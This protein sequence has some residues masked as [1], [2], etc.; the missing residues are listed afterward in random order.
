M[1][2]FIHKYWSKATFILLL[3]GVLLQACENDPQKV[4]DLFRKQVAVE[5]AFNV[6]SFMSQDGKVKAKLTA[7][8]MVRS[9]ADSPYLEF[10]KTVHVDFY[11]DSATIETILDARYAK[12]M[13]YMR[14]VLLKDSVVVINR[15][16]GD[17]LRTQELWWDQN[18]EEFYTDKPCHINQR[19]GK[20]FAENGLRA[21]QNLNWYEFHKSS[22]TRLVPESGV[23][24]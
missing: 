2:S 12:Y 10:P 8:Y 23:P 1:Y 6:E 17:T 16:S 15:L 3:G 19:L 22:G 7:P 21:A 20:T 18:K 9:Q 13:E 24:N 11:K 5:E 14:K 4:N